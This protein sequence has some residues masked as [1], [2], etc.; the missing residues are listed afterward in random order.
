MCKLGGRGQTLTLGVFFDNSPLDEIGS[1]T[2]FGTH[3]L[4]QA[5]WTQRTC[6]SLSHTALPQLLCGSWESVFKF[7]ML[8]QQAVYLLSCFLSSEWKLSFAITNVSKLSTETFY[9]QCICWQ[10][11]FICKVTTVIAACST[12][13]NWSKF[14]LKESLEY[15]KRKQNLCIYN[16]SEHLFVF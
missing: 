12:K 1:F 9:I 16:F 15:I 10:C 8:P 14:K 6:L 11:F 2:E 13:K 3:W 5:G 4:G 7:F